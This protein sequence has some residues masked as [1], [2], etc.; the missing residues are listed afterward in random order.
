MPKSVSFNE[1]VMYPMLQDDL[2]ALSYLQECLADDDPRVFLLALRDLI[3][4]RNV[5]MTE[6]AKRTGIQRPKL[7]RILSLQGNPEWKTIYAILLALGL[8][9]SV[10]QRKQASA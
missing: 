2:Q 1:T 3:A 6:L 10:D 8:Q 9:F 4:A 5:T 7:Y